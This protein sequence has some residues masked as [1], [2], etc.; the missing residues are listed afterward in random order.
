[1]YIWR[2]VYKSLQQEKVKHREECIKLASVTSTLPAGRVRHRRC[3]RHNVT[4]N[5]WEMCGSKL[6]LQMTLYGV[7]FPPLNLTAKAGM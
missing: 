4:I 1:M 6:G 5:K 2:L 3:L 7:T